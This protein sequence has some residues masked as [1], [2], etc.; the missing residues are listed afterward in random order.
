[1]QSKENTTKHELADL[2]SKQHSL[3]P[4]VDDITNGKDITEHYL[5]EVN[6]KCNHSPQSATSC[7]IA[8]M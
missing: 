8:V 1:M 3:L 7:P 6:K 4:T 5:G 2:F